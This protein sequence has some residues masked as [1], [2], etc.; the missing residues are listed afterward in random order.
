MAE[1]YRSGFVA[2]VGRPNVGK[3]TLVNALVGRR[4]SI[5]TARPQ[6]TRQAITGI[7]TRSD[8]Q[9]AFVD[10]PGLHTRVRNLLNRA[11]NR[12][13]SGALAGA[14]LALMV[15]DAT[16]WRTEDDYVLEQV[17]AA[18]LPVILVVNKTD[19]LRRKSLLLP[20]LQQCAGLADFREIVPIAARDGD[21]LDCLP[22][23]II[24]CLPEGPMLYPADTTT[25]RGMEFRLAE[26]IREKLLTELRQEVPYGLAVE[27]VQLEQKPGRTLV[28]AVI[29]ASRESH[30]G[31]VVGQKGE[32][33]KR[34]GTAARLDMEAQFGT[35]FHLE[36]RV[37]VKRDWADSERVLQQFGYE[38]Q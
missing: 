7:L 34:V 18:G 30:K 5:V 31:I 6:T 19:Q 16:G 21:N 1:P 35:R 20:F 22:G 15:V 37:K 9:I 14:D 28:D 2:V 13:V 29:W 25:D 3:S 27:I 26:I 8:A 10:T 12:A 24:A 33:L 38:V 32:T 36:T 4:I 23:L 17:R 11:M